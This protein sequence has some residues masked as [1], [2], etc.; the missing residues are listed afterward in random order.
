M[1]EIT[2]TPSSRGFLLPVHFLSRIKK[3]LSVTIVFV[4]KQFLRM[5]PGSVLLSHGAGPHWLGRSPEPHT[6]P[7]PVTGRRV[8]ACANTFHFLSRI[9]KGLSVRI[10][11]VVKQ[12]LRMGPGS[13]LL[14][15]GAGPHWL[16]HTG[17][18]GHRNPTLS[19]RQLLVAE[20]RHALIRFT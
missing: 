19:P 8:S 16:G 1:Y 13:V 4:V 10:V 17:W 6:I 9:K 5:G 18:A 12:F 15:H 14:S 20:S 11:F 2:K 7:T 3:G